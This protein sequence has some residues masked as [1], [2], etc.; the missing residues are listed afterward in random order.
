MN[1]CPGPSRFRPLWSWTTCQGPLL[2]TRP[3]F[4]FL[5]VGF[6][7][8]AKRSRSS[9]QAVMTASS[10]LMHWMYA[11]QSKHRRV[12]PCLLTFVSSSSFRALSALGFI[13]SQDYVILG[14]ALGND[15][16]SHFCHVIFGVYSFISLLG[17]DPFSCYRHGTDGLLDE[18]AGP[19]LVE[20][21]K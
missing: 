4:L 17:D 3:S 12:C 21:L 9:T 19:H 10:S 7:D 2:L 1:L 16:T 6:V 5:F 13:G 8:I 15:S 20:L 18:F 11:H 14:A